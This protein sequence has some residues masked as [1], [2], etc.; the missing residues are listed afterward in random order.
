M[1]T[2]NI[3]VQNAIESLQASPATA[4]IAQRIQLCA[5]CLDNVVEVSAEW[6]ETAAVAKGLSRPPRFAPRTF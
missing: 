4:S 3:D 6:A 5:E 2:M 1:E